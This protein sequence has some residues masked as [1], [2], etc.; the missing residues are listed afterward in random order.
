MVRRMRLFSSVLMAAAALTI[1]G[2]QAQEDY[3]HAF[4][5]EGVTKLV[6]NDRVNIWEV[7]WITGVKQPIHRHRYDM[8]GVYLRYGPITVTRPDGTANPPSAPFEIP[9]P[10]FQAKGVTHREEALN[11]PGTPERLAIMVDLKYE[12]GAPLPALTVNPKLPKSFPRAGVEER[13]RERARPDVGLHLGARQTRRP[14]RARHGHDRGLPRRRR[15]RVD[16]QRGQ[17]DAAH[18]RVEVGAVRSPRHGGHRG[19]HDRDRHERS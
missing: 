5:R 6:D 1:V 11:P 18:R 15:H 17:D 3:P 13:A 9:R 8:A 12:P 14:A 19:G 4:P 10:Y 7:N 16:D 2:P